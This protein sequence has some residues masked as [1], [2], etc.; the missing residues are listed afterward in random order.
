[1]LIRGGAKMTNTQRLQA[2]IDSGKDIFTTKEL[3]QSNIHHSA[4]QAFIKSGKL[5]KIAYGVYSTPEA[6]KDKMYILQKRNPSIIYSH[7]TA[8]FLHDL[9]DRDPLFYSVTVP[10]GYNTKRFIDAG[11]DVHLIKRNLHRVGLTQRKTVFG[12]DV[13][14]YDIERTICDIIRNRNKTDA[15]VLTQALKRY[16]L[17]KDK[18][19]NILMNY[20]EQFR[21]IKPLR[22]Y[23]E[24]L[25]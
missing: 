5:D 14:V 22:V 23:L 7:E 3:Q 19:L 18:N 15:D 1:M 12:H 17:R 20:A 9:T 25:L 2:Y 4:L 13:I 21:V 16:V 6:L 10:S 24:V 11:L 8:L